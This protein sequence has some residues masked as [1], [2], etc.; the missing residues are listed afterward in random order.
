[1]EK[2]STKEHKAM[3]EGRHLVMIHVYYITHRHF[4]LHFLF[5]PLNVH[6]TSA[7]HIVIAA[8]NINDNLTLCHVLNV[9]MWLK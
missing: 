6:I 5:F 4:F 8:S 7:Y 3:E 2:H 9:T 1:M